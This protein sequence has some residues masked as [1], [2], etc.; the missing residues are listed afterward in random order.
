MH[1]P[2]SINN[3]VVNENKL[4]NDDPCDL[5]L[6]RKY[7]L[8]DRYHA[9]LIA[10][11]MAPNGET[12]FTRYYDIADNEVCQR[13]PKNIKCFKCRNELYI[14]RIINELYNCSYD[15]YYLIKSSADE[16]AWAMENDWL[17]VMEN[18][19]N[20]QLVAASIIITNPNKALN[21]YDYNSVRAVRASN[22]LGLIWEQ[23]D[24]AI[25][26]SLIINENCRG[27]GLMRMSLMFCSEIARASNKRYVYS[28]V[29]PN[30]ND[31][32]TAYE[33]MEYTKSGNTFY[34]I[35]EEDGKVN[36]YPRLIM[37][38]NIFQ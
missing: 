9:Y 19:D 17:W 28:T 10:N 3:N 37:K 32:K 7:Y 13:P 20:H 11:D 23:G 38:Q 14:A 18:V 8:T 26:D 21:Q 33:D 27:L 34:E 25:L 35:K 5:I 4:K 31:Y 15:P 16:I 2:K 36:T 29:S 24:F 6:G 30:N 1:N 22:D 12:K